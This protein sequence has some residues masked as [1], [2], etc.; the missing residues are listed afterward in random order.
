MLLKKNID[1]KMN[2]PIVSIIIPCYNQS[3]FLEETLQSVI[4]QTYANWECLIINDGSPDDTEIIAKEW[5]RKDDRFKYFHKE[6]GGL[7]SARNLGILKS[8]ADF[9]LTLDSDDK[10][11]KTFIEKGLVILLENEN[12]GIV[13][14]WGFRFT[15][16]KTY[17]LFKPTGKSIEDF[18]YCNAAIGTSLFRK[19]CWE[20]VE[21][22]DEKM[23]LGYED[24]E[25]YL[26]VCQKDWKVHI[27]Q[28]PLFF[29]RQHNVSMR[30]IAINKHDFKIK[31][32]IFL[33]HDTFYKQYSKTMMI[34]FL[35]DLQ[36]E[37]QNNFKIKNT[38]DYRLGAIILK[39]FR[40]I[41]SK[42]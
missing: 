34:L 9:I 24:W 29:Y 4:N 22:Y 18:I 1:L 7:S 33:K 10:Y 6:N 30:T 31:K 20:Q 41:K 16:K 5:I 19:K 28:E 12:I 11:E 37:K 13:S 14:S 15:D 36:N 42:F 39:P 35:S 21:G 3:Q 25:F 23:I 27:I 38:F 2:N 8:N 40:W 26:R 17:G 32:Y